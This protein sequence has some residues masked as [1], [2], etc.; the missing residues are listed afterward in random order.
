MITSTIAIAAGIHSGDKTHHQDQAITLHNFNTINAMA[1][2]PHKPIPPPDDEE[3][4]LIYNNVF[5]K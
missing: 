2:K 1:R 5:N 4:L 3:L